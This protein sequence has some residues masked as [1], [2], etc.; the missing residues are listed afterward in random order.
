VNVQKSY[1]TE[2]AK[3]EEEKSD[4]N[5]MEELLKEN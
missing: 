1:L 4:T 2:Q 5:D 3:L